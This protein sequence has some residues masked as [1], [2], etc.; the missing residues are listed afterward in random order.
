MAG[1]RIWRQRLGDAG[2]STEISCYVTRGHTCCTT[3]IIKLVGQ[4]LCRDVL[5]HQMSAHTFRVYLM[6]FPAL[7]TKARGISLMHLCASTSYVEQRPTPQRPPASPSPLSSP[8][9]VYLIDF[10]PAGHLYNTTQYLCVC[11]RSNHSRIGCE[12]IEVKVETFLL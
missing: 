2:R 9:L 8:D 5:I 11:V 7:W 12:L 4:S 6:C 3:G 10:H 1:L